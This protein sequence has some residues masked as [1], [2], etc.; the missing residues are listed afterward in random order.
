MDQNG[1]TVI[2]N[3]NSKEHDIK[4]EKS[5]E[6]HIKEHEKSKEHHIK[7]HETLAKRKEEL[8]KL[9][10]QLADDTSLHGFKQIHDNKGNLLFELVVWSLVLQFDPRILFRGANQ[11]TFVLVEFLSHLN[12]TIFG[13]A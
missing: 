6:H 8:L 1:N 7:E 10:Q 12:I 2:E 4:D 5:K 11:Y 13:W 3:K 9:I